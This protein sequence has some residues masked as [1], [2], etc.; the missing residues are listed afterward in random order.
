M[1]VAFPSSTQTASS[2]A[3]GGGSVNVNVNPPS[4]L[5][6][7][8]VWAI[9]AV[10]DHDSSTI[11]TPS[12][13]T[14][15]HAQLDGTP[16]YPGVRTYWKIAGDS[17]SAV[18]VSSSGGQNY[19]LWCASVRIT[20]AN[21]ANPIGNVAT[22]TPTGTGTTLGAPSVTI[23]N[24]GS[25]A[26][27]ILAASPPSGSLS[28]TQPSGSTMLQARHQGNDFPSGAVAYELRNAGSY[29]PGTWSLH[30]ANVGEGRIGVTIEILPAGGGGGGSALPILIANHRGRQMFDIVKKG[31]TDRSVKVHIM[32][33]TSGAPETGTVYNTSGLDL[34]YRREGGARTAITEATLASLTAAHAD[35]GFLHISDGDYRLDMPDAAYSTGANFFDFGG[36]VTG[37]IVIGGRV[38]L[39]DIDPE[40]TIRAGLTA[41]PNAV[42][43]ASGGLFTRGSGAGQINQ[44]ANGRIDVNIVAVSEDATAAQNLESYCDG[45][46]PIPANV[47]QFGGSNG[48]F[49]SGRPEVNVS[50][51]GGSAGTFSGGIPAVNTVQWRGVQPSNLASGRVDATVGAMQSA[52]VT[53]TAIAED[54]IGASELA[55][56][57]VTEIVNAI[58]A[59][60]VETQGSITLQ[61]ALSVMLA[62]LAGESE[63]G[64]NTFLSPNG[65][66]TR[67]T[68]TTNGN[69]ER[70]AMSLT[71]SS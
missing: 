31:S 49:A 29:S 14:P 28:I 35:G 61:Q 45:T 55:T 63:N 47:T 2:D 30:G 64:G 42:A 34:W 7:G 6:T 21:T 44:D 59:A 27:L 22:T 3:A 17:E 51:Y 15:A 25:G 37:K 12:G 39:V 33:A 68:A 70:T 5:T 1:A 4:G 18:N 9:V 32:D 52:V 71:P 56:D 20:G 40:D 24:A 65:E 11:A 62:V 57:A 54:A 38:R 16:G 41:L 23:Q 43:S 58:K 13:F 19:V 48:T 10:L 53:A 67:V 36:T 66:A 26:L 46:T 60:V 69:K 50:H 8:D